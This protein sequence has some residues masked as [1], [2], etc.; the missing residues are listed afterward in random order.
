MFDSHCHFDFSEFDQQR[1]GMWDECLAL[2]IRGLLIPGVEPDQ[3]PRASA[4]STAH[5]GMLMAAGL[6]PWWVSTAELPANDVWQDVLASSRC[7]AIG[8]CGLDAC[9]NTPM[10]LQQSIFERHLQMAVD[11]DMPLIIHVRQ[12]HNETIR[13]LK[14]YRPPRAGVIH[15]FTGSKE[16]AMEYWRMGFRLGIGGAITYPRANKTRQMVVSMPV[17]SL[18][19]ETDAPDMPLHGAQGQVNHPMRLVDVANSLAIQR[20]ESLGTIANATTENTCTLFGV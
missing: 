11:C 17:E 8:E 13:L 1:E 20:G 10:A 9:I 4:I 12:T 14:Q 19:L 7:V 6:H 16:L 2:G 15:G 3:W 18:L 5:T